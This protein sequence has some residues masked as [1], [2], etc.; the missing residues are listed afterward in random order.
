MGPGTSSSL[1]AK[2]DGE[3][4]RGVLGLTLVGCFRR[5]MQES[6]A[7]IHCC[8]S[9]EFWAGK[10]KRKGQSSPIFVVEVLAGINN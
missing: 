3:G 4:G 9:S 5:L 10:E 8:R 7:D 1:K 6:K 2:W